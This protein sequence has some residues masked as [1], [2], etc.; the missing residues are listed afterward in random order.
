MVNF[1]GSSYYP[2]FF[3]G[4]GW[5][6]L[7]LFYEIL[8][9]GYTN[10]IYNRFLTV[11]PAWVSIIPLKDNSGRILILRN[12]VFNGIPQNNSKFRDL[13]P[14]E[15]KNSVNFHMNSLVRTSALVPRV[16]LSHNMLKHFWRIHCHQRSPYLLLYQDPLVFFIYRQG[17][18]S[19]IS[20]GVVC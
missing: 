10:L 7:L 4:Y 15:L 16:D 2:G 1:A 8:I 19:S 12:S 17:S 9:Y 18:K 13:I 3:K 5:T 14:T 6:P 20:W 11:E